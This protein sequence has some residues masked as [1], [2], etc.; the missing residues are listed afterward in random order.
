MS[1]HTSNIWRFS[2]SPFSFRYGLLFR[3]REFFQLMFINKKFRGKPLFNHA[4]IYIIWLIKPGKC[5]SILVRAK[6][7]YFECFVFIGFKK[8]LCHLISLLAMF[9]SVNVCQPKYS[10][11]V[12]FKSVSIY[13]ARNFNILS[14]FLGRE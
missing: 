3:E 5:P 14:V 7:Y 6:S 10:P 2:P 9:W 8:I 13:N 11:I 12:C 1:L 4:Q